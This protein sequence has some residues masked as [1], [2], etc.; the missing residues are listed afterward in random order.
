[1]KEKKLFTIGYY[2]IYEVNKN[3][4]TQY[5]VDSGK[6][7]F[8]QRTHKRF[9]NPYRDNKIFNSVDD[10]KKYVTTKLKKKKP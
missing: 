8:S 10:A 3:G 5:R 6:T 9:L 2:S 7:I 4:E 1:M